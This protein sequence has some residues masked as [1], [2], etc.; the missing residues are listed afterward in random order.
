MTFRLAAP[1][2]INLGLAITGKRADGYHEIV[3]AMHAVGLFDDL[4][5]TPA[6]APHLDVDVPD[7]A[8]EENL[9]LRA[10]HAWIAAADHPAPL[11]IVLHKRIPAAAGLGGA[12]SDAA[13]TLRLASAAFPV[14]AGGLDLATIAGTLGSDVPFFLDG[15]AA[16][17]TGRGERL[18]R[19][20]PRSGLWCVLATPRVEI[21]RKTTTLYSMLTP[22]DFRPALQPEDVVALWSAAG[23]PAADTLANAFARPLLA[24]FP[25]LAAVP[26]ALQAAGAPL[27]ALSGAGP[28]WYA[29]TDDA[30]LAQSIASGAASRLRDT[31]IAVVPLLTA[32][33][34]LAT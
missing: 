17:A 19:L 14:A 13:A 30:Q 5:A 10:L 15:P 31:L 21:P 16:L 12:S 11:H 4:V 22:A 28:T 9:V 32:M 25:D 27:V 18:A 33:P 1:A 29:L 2:K 26:A 34:T 24:A 23:I 20:P 6:G 3:T 7:L 8:G